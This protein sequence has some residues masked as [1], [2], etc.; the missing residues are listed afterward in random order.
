MKHLSWG[1]ALRIGV[2]LLAVVLL[3]FYVTS[4][5][6]AP[7]PPSHVV[8]STGA[9]GG[10]YERYAKRYQA[11]FARNG[12]TLELRASEGAVENLNRLMSA[13]VDAAF[14][15]GGVA[16]F[17]DEDA[18]SPI[19]SLGALYLEPVWV[20]ARDTPKP[21]QQLRDLAGRRVGIGA[22][23]SGTQPLARMLLETVGVDMRTTTLLPLSSEQ[24]SAALANGTVSYT[25]LTLPTILRV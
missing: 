16:P 17:Q 18:D 4:R 10:A 6:V 7:A 20:F 11:F 19:A 24:A 21:V 23:G 22:E 1:D 9:P 8:L 15:Q 14:V 5:F 2:P 3:A 25:H 13:S 12:V